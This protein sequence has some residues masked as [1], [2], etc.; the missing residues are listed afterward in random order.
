VAQFV[1]SRLI[2]RFL[3]LEGAKADIQVANLQLRLHQRTQHLSNFPFDAAF[4][5]RHLTS[6]NM[7]AKLAVS[8]VARKRSCS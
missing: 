3:K 5:F 6:V 8:V 7:K 4:E 2:V 1:T